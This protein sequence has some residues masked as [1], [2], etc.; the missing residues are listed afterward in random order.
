MPLL[1][2]VYYTEA[3]VTLPAEIQRAPCFLLQRTHVNQCCFPLAGQCCECFT[4]SQL[5]WDAVGLGLPLEMPLAVTFCSCEWMINL[6]TRISRK[7][8]RR[9]EIIVHENFVAQSLNSSNNLQR[10][11]LL[12]ELWHAAVACLNTHS[13]HKCS[14]ES[15][16]VC[17]F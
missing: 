10:A 6:Q 12:F 17:K 16:K 1:E 9:C 8:S 3:Y 4:S 5:S 14:P 7:Q 13:Y 15:R 11:L 2:A